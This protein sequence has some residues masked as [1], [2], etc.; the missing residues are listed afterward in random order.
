MNEWPFIS[1]NTNTDM[2]VFWKL[3]LGNLLGAEAFFMGCFN[4]VL[5]LKINF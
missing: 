1:I 4:L 5:E 2:Y 3:C